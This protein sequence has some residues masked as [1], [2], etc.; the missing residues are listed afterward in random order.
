MTQPWYPFYW[1][2]YSGKTMHLTQGEHGAYMLL[3]RFIYTTGK[4]IPDKQRYSIARAMLEQ[5]CSNVD[6]VLDQFFV[7]EGDGWVNPTVSEVMNEAE[8]RHKRRASAGKKGGEAKAKQCSS[9][10]K[11]TTATATAKSKNI[12]PL[13][14]SIVHSPELDAFVGKDF[15]NFNDALLAC[16]A[17][18]G[19][20]QLAI[21]D[22]ETLCGWLEKYDMN[23]LVM[24]TVAEQIISYRK[25]NGG[26]RPSTL[27]YFNKRLAERN[28]MM[29]LTR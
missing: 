6:A 4:P 13:P 12:S 20:K 7:L 27:A 16:S 22:Q 1:S 26:S 9:N 15:N 21:A 29:E 2:D 3:M 5:E 14:P 28:E 24:P 11:A 10:A 19:V 25:K 18:M 17:L 8:E 23:K